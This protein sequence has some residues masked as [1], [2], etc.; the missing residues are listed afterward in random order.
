MWKEFF[1]Q[2]RGVGC[3]NYVFTDS[4]NKSGH[5]LK[6]SHQSGISQAFSDISCPKK[7]GERPRLG[8]HPPEGQSTE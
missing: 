6:W 3:G 4:G 5:L 7:A 2:G 1:L 8:S